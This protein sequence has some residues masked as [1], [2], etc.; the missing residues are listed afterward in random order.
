LVT[1]TLLSTF[2]PDHGTICPTVADYRTFNFDGREVRFSNPDKIYF[3]KVGITKGQ[4]CQYYIDCGD[5][6][7]NHVRERPIV[8][9]RYTG[10]VESK[11][12]YQKRVPPHH[13]DWLETTVISFP[14]GRTAEELV[15][16]DIAH[17]IWA[18]SLGNIDFNPHPVRRSDLEHPDELRVDL[19]PMTDASWEKVT[20]VALIANEVL[21]ENKLRGYPRTSGSRGMHII[22]RIH[23]HWDFN[24][25]RRAA[26]ALAR[27]VERRVPK[28]ATSKWWKE[29]RLPDG[30]FVDYNQNAKDRTVACAYSVRPVADARVACP[31]EWDEV[32]GCDPEKLTLITVPERLSKSGDPSADIDENA[33]SLEG[34]LALAQQDVEERG[35]KDAPWPPHY[36]KQQDEPKRVQPSRARPE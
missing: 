26:L 28:I 21:Q 14:S 25:V 2:V 5:A 16:T 22:V 10:G 29:E 31:L 11:P 20:Q 12:F 33:G 30:V 23:P 24:D 18:V 19:D 4:L 13:P 36:E 17:I 1:A 6:L 35:L 7:L 8:L 34:L 32:P 9:K 27:E 15:P 3:P